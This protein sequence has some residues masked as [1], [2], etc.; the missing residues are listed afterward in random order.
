MKTRLVPVCFMVYTIFAS[1]TVEVTI[2]F[3]IFFL[4]KIKNHFS[5]LYNFFLSFFRT[6]SCSLPFSSHISHFYIFL[7]LLLLFSF[8]SVKYA[9]GCGALAFFNFLM[10]HTQKQRHRHT[11]NYCCCNVN[12]NISFS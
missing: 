7:F 10:S 4:K 11:R 5:F 8:S 1:L 2:K 12:L 6:L 3:S 9:F